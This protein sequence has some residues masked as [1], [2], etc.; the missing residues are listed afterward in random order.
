[1]NA[2]LLHVPHPPARP[3]EPADFSYLKLAP[4][5]AVARPPPAA[6]VDE[7]RQLAVSL[8]RILDDEGR[9]QGPWDPRLAPAQ[10]STNFAQPV[11][12]CLRTSTARGESVPCLG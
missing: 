3:G 12:R 11:D 2:P 5:G 9:A 1:M 6:S 7:T 4:A 8:V 10:L